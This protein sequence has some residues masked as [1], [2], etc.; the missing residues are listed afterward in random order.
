MVIGENEK[1]PAV[2][3]VPAFE[4]IKQWCAKRNIIYTTNENMINNTDLIN[5]IWREVES[6]NQE[7]AQHEKI[8]KMKLLPKEWTI[9]HGELTPKLSLKRKV[10]MQANK[11]LYDEIYI[12]MI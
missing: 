4:F 5:R 7:L 2:F 1:F 3:I 12:H 10:I 9:D 8:K 6:A 11:K